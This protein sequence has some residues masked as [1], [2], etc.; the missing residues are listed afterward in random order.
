MRIGIGQIAPTCPGCLTTQPT[1]PT[2][3]QVNAFAQSVGFNCASGFTISAAMRTC[4][5]AYC[6]PQAASDLFCYNNTT[7]KTSAEATS[8]STG[9]ILLVGAA[10]AALLLPGWMKLIALPLGLFGFSEQ[11]AGSGGF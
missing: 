9:T 8:T 4:G 1:V 2:Q 6:A 5:G 10:A 11:L 3:A 7:N